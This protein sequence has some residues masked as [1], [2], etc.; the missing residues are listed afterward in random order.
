MFWTT[1]NSEATIAT[2]TSV[3]N[4]VH[5]SEAT[6]ATETSVNNSV[7]NSEATIST[8]TS[9]NNNQSTRCHVSEEFYFVSVFHNTVL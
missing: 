1:L 3:N 7:N 8:E 2:E 5:N 4:S 9:V 6:I